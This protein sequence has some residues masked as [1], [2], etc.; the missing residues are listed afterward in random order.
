MEARLCSQSPTE[1]EELLRAANRDAETLQTQAEELLKQQEHLPAIKALERALYVRYKALQYRQALDQPAVTAPEPGALTAVAEKLV[2]SYN[3]AA[4]R[5]LR[6]G[7]FTTALHLL[8]AA[9]VLTEEPPPRIRKTANIIELKRMFNRADRT[10]EAPAM[11]HSGVTVHEYLRGDPSLRRK[12]RALTLNNLGCLEK[13]RDHLA[14]AAKILR[15]AASVDGVPTGAALINLSAVL[16]QQ[17]SHEEA[18]KCAREAVAALESPDCQEDASELP[19]L[20]ALALHN[21]A[22]ALGCVDVEN[23]R[24]A[25]SKAFEAAVAAFGPNDEKTAAVARG[26]K[27][28]QALCDAMDQHRKRMPSIKG[29]AM[30]FVAASGAVPV[31]PLQPSPPPKGPSVPTGRTADAAG[32]VS[33]PTEGQAAEAKLIEVV[34]LKGASSGTLEEAATP[35]KAGASSTTSATLIPHRPSLDSI[36]GMAQRDR[37]QLAQAESARKEE[38]LSFLYVA[39]GRAPSPRS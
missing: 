31:G 29:S 3:A 21:L 32:G 39:L 24:T 36:G 23:S 26:F 28:M 4:M 9:A 16:T 35:P 22:I 20:R 17:G 14:D 5:L 11:P 30:C 37:E 2:V 13:R 6:K 33:A 10:P 27:R 34:S 15:L 19:M 8:E 1:L 12:L 18:V 7:E 25:Y 38:V